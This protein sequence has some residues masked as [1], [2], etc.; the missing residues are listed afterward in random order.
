MKFNKTDF[1]IFRHLEVVCG[2]SSGIYVHRRCNL[3]IFFL[4]LFVPR[5]KTKTTRNL[6]KNSEWMC[7]AIVEAIK[8]FQVALAH[9]VDMEQLPDFRNIR[10]WIELSEDNVAASDWRVFLLRTALVPCQRTF[11]DVATFEHCVEEFLGLFKFLGVSELSVSV[12]SGGVYG[13]LSSLFQREFLKQPQE[14]NVVPR[15]GVCVSL[16]VNGW[17]S[18]DPKESIE[19]IPAQ[20]VTVGNAWGI[21]VSCWRSWRLSTS[22]I[23]GFQGMNCRPV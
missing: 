21:R 19:A 12:L 8:F 7:Y 11:A 13:F 2:V 9:I 23:C 15:P 22:F 4:F 3:M 17:L 5:S 16:R 6:G 14:D 18:H 10:A 20:S 1:L